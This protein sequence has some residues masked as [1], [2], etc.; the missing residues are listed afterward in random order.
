MEETSRAGSGRTSDL[1]ALA[2]YSVVVFVCSCWPGH[3]FRRKAMS[4]LSL[5]HAPIGDND[6]DYDMLAD[7]KVAE[8]VPS[9]IRD[10]LCRR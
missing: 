3:I 10:Q 9:S 5:K 1:P 6:D 2:I 8:L 4:P 7:G